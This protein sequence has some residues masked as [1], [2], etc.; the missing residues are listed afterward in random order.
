MT[1]IVHYSMF[2]DGKWVEAKDGR[3]LMSANP[4]TGE[5][6]ASFPEAGAEDV[7]DAVRAAHR[8][9]TQGPW[10][11]MS[12]TE[13]GKK[14][15]RLADLLA[16]QADA[17]ARLETTDTGKLIRE[18]RSQTRY[19][20]EYLQ[21]FAG[22]ADKLEGAT[23]P[24]DKPDLFV[25]TVREPIGVVAG[26]VPWNSQLLL[27][28]VKLGPALATGNAI[29]LK[30]SEHGP[31]PL[32]ELA[33]LC[34]EA[35]I[36]P[37]V[38]NVVTG[39]GDPCGQALTTHPLV[40]RIAFTGGPS[41]ARH[42]IRNSAENFG[43]VSLELG[44]KSPILVFDDADLDSAVNGILAGNFGATGQSCVAG[45]RVFIQAGVFDE[46]VGRVAER[47]K[48]IQI[49]NPMDE[50]TE[51]GPLATEAQRR[52]I[53]RVVAVSLEE[54]A[55][56]VTG[57]VRPSAQPRGWYFE[58]TILACRQPEVSAARQEL[59]GPVLSAFR[60]DD[61]AAGVAAANDTEYGLAAGIFTRDSARS[62][63]V[64]RQLRAG[65]VWINTYRA[66]SPLAPF[67][68]FKASGYGRESG[69]DSLLD[70][71]RTKT[72]WIDTSTK[73]MGDPFIMR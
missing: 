50:T 69:R 63:R 17:V 27:A 46:V 41:T 32:L 22:A 20:A 1:E 23:L 73:P 11:R 60:F 34:A 70:Y 52:N 13:R 28:A 14:L 21:Y 68:G 8:A 65:I 47:A 72:V 49:G 33:R 18:T 64:M 53:E 19:V 31:V 9:M 71:T 40:A 39:L 36:P 2:I 6:W 59:F 56:L 26:I 45:S 62:L 51:M 12:A 35:E 42:I 43:V 57:G 67:G 55:V 7:D 58:P 30:A 25:M 48:R 16:A 38:V 10:A 3:R 24:I 37:G 15:R 61:D 54:G 29:V 4:A 5:A 44:G 66:G